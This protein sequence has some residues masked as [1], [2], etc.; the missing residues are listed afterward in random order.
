M[1]TQKREANLSFDFRPKNA[2]RRCDHSGCEESGDFRA[3]KSRDRLREYYWFCLEHV[4]EYNKGWN[5]YA[6]LSEPEIENMVRFDTVWNRQ[7]WPM[8]GL[9]AH[10]NRLRAALDREF[11]AGPGNGY[12]APPRPAPT[13]EEGHA[14][15]VLDLTIP[16]EFAAIKAR[17]IELVKEHHPDA[18]GGSKESEEKLKSINLAFGVLK[19][20]FAS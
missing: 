9:N 15:A 1:R 16:V 12:Q 7:T 2:G 3:P 5:Y 6:G 18:N 10:E 13:T 11:A 20:S 14:L 19:A 4:R 8:G 17:Y